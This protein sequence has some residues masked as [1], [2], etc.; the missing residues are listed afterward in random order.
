M[1]NATKLE[2]ATG[3]VDKQ[4]RAGDGEML[5]FLESYCTI[6]FRLGDPPSD[7]MARIKA[8]LGEKF[9][10]TPPAV[11][12]A[13][14]MYRMGKMLYPDKKLSIGQISQALGI[15]SYAATRK[16]DWW[17]KNGLARRIRSRQDRRMVKIC[18]TE[19][20]QRFHEATE[21]STARGLKSAMACLTDEERSTFMALV[22]KMASHLEL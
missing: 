19:N 1:Q 21:N 9:V 8:E 15:P 3:T 2:G 12:T 20:G 6:N 10:I 16:V 17:V 4:K 18:L 13:P 11:I 5:R 22:T 7:E 14:T